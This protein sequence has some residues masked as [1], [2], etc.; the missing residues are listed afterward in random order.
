MS[1]NRSRENSQSLGR[2]NGLMPPN[3]NA[4]SFIKRNPSFQSSS[5]VPSQ[6]IENYEI[7]DEN[8][9]KF[10]KHMVNKEHN[11]NFQS[12]NEEQVEVNNEVV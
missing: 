1:Q 9:H 5:N 8:T 2:Q 11:S 10:P 3:T 7:I 12:I 6:H 4:Y